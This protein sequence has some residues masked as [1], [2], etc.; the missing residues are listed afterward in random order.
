MRTTLAIILLF[1]FKSLF[2]TSANDQPNII[3]ILTD[4]AGYIDWGFQGSDVME[5]PRIDQLCSEGTKFSQAYVTN[6]VCAPS[7]AGLITGRYQNRFGF[8]ANIVDF[9]IAPGK[10][11][12]DIGLDT[13]ELT[14]ANHLKALGYSTA[15][16]G[17]W[18]LGDRNHHHPNSRGFDYFYGLLSGSRPYFHTSNLPDGQKLMRN[19]E[20]DDLTEGYMTDVLTDDAINWMKEKVESD[21]NKP[22]FTYLSYTAV[23]GPYESKQEDFDHFT[24]NCVGFDGQDCS[25][26]RQNYAAMTYNLD[27]NIGKLVDSLKAMD[28]YQN[29]LIFFIN[30]NGGKGPGVY[31]DNGDLRGGKSNGYEGGLRVPFFCVWPEQIPS[32]NTY[33]KQVISLDIATTAIKAAGGTFPI[34]KP[35]DGVDLLPIMQDTSLLAH[36]YLFWKKQWVWDIV[37]KDNKKLMVFHNGTGEEDNDTV[38]YELDEFGRGEWNDLYASLKDSVVS[39]MFTEFKTWESEMILPW[40]FTKYLKATMC[41]DAPATI[42]DCEFLAEK[43][44]GITTIW[45]EEAENG[46]LSGTAEIKTGCAN[47]SGGEFVKLLDVAG[48]SLRFANIS[49]PNSGSYLLKIYYFYDGESPLE[50]LVNNVSYGIKQFPSAKWCYQAPAEEFL[51]IIDLKDGDNTIEF[52]VANGLPAPF[53]DYVKIIEVPKLEVNLSVSSE[54]IVAGQEIRIKVE[55]DELL[56]SQETVDVA[57]NG[58]PQESYEL[59]ATTISIPANKNSGTTTFKYT[60]ASQVPEEFTIS[61]T[62]ASPGIEIGAANNIAMHVVTSPSNYYVSS[63]GGDDTNNGLSPDTPWASL[64]RLAKFSFVPGDSILFKSGDTFIGQLK[65]LGS[66]MDGSPIVISNFGTGDIP[67]FDGAKAEGGA[68][69]AAIFFNNQEY[70]EVENLEITNERLIPRQGFSDTD[71]FGILVYNDGDKVMRHFRFRKLKIR[72]VYAI[73]L[74][75]VE[76]NKI[77]VSGIYFKTESNTESGNEKHI[78]DIVIENCYITHTA[79]FGIFSQHGGGIEG[80]GNDSINRNMNLV[81]RNN[82]FYELGG[83][84]IVPGRSFNCLVENNVF[85]YCG[86]DYDSRMANR[87]SGAWF[88]NCRN[89]IAQYNKSLHI[90]GYND[91]YGMHIDFGNKN[92]FLQYNYSEDSEGGFVEILGK[93]KN[94]VYRFNLSINDGFRDKH[95][96]TL[97]VSTYAGSSTRIPSDSNFIYN[98]TIYADAGITPDIYIEG[99]NTFV[100]NNIFYAAGNTQMAESVTV[101][102]HNGAELFMSNNLFY[103]NIN[104]V[105]ATYDAQ[106]VFEDPLFAEPGIFEKNGYLLLEESP[107]YQNGTIFPE[108]IFPMAGKGIFKDVKAYPETDLYGD[109][110]NIGHEIPNIGASNREVEK[111]N[112]LTAS[113]VQA[114]IQLYPNPVVELLGIRLRNNQEAIR[115]IEIYDNCGR[116]IKRERVKKDNQQYRIY[117]GSLTPGTYSLS[118]Q[119]DMS[120]YSKLFIKR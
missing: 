67:L 33:K 1:I 21:A 76:F 38:L 119:T 2:A 27:Y 47:S 110:V 43:Y 4:D 63:S 106:P 15:A 75:G 28:I 61:V 7:R 54:R 17:K 107:A 108:P 10:S 86:S 34:E 13:T 62:N 57:I 60:N 97:W 25:E 40:W 30:D 37:M 85:E 55:A 112:S 93:N 11:R 66:G 42:E 41:G 50:I 94:S 12:D 73:S 23:H 113:E 39:D 18:H 83:S 26:K 51:A 52:R 65:F 87:G 115:Q 103:G 29:T 71:A 81:F 120:N 46:I 20:Y 58:I 104:P 72:D 105:F 116:I 74:D 69:N 118:V 45:E 64:E 117:V 90:R 77:K 35:L 6:S 3:I 59:G 68:Y 36:E 8:D 31:T 111:V 44:G 114:E 19:W 109:Y 82:H 96:N 98:N 79:R 89:V 56:G 24:N 9:T 49:A 102:L 70:I 78:R 32:N 91:S 84:G 53:I 95:G 99:E 16:I 100:Y 14:L 92:V 101:K 80:V 22:F 5:T 88:W 48:N